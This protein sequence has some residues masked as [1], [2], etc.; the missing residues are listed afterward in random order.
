MLVRIAEFKINFMSLTQLF[1][2][3][4][5]RLQFH[6]T[7]KLLWLLSRDWDLQLRTQILHRV[8]SHLFP[9]SIKRVIMKSATEKIVAFLAIVSA[10]NVAPRW[11]K[12]NSVL[13]FTWMNSVF[14]IFS[15]NILTSILAWFHFRRSYS[16]HLT[17]ISLFTL[18]IREII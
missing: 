3:L 16:L 1:L 7:H 4:R 6:V 15:E 12:R 10:R 2:N 8:P 18:K 13:Q 11:K 5:E 14:F 9:V 17:A